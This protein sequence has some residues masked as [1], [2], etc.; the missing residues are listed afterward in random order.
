MTTNEAPSFPRSSCLLTAQAVRGT[1]ISGSCTLVQ[2]KW[3]PQNQI[4][5]I[6]PWELPCHCRNKFGSLCYVHHVDNDNS[7]QCEDKH[8]WGAR[9]QELKRCRIQIRSDPNAKYLHWSP[10]DTG[11]E[12]V[13]TLVLPWIWSCFSKHKAPLLW[14]TALIFNLVCGGPGTF[15]LGDP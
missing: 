2:M 5:L 9:V 8:G 13:S 12:R 1:L 6:S 10:W 3:T 11:T 14:K 4:F 7:V 15:N